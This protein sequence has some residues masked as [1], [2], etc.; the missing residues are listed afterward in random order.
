MS[1][2]PVMEPIT[3]DIVVGDER[4]GR[5]G[6]RERLASG[7]TNLRESRA[8]REWTVTLHGALWIGG[9]DLGLVALLGKTL[10]L[11][12]TIL[13][14]IGII[15]FL[16]VL[17]L[18]HRGGHPGFSK[19]EMRCAIAATFMVVYFTM[20]GVL[21]FSN[22]DLSPVA[23]TLIKNF[24]YLVGGV[25]AFYFGSTA[26]VEHAAAKYGRTSGEGSTNKTP[27]PSS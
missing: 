18:S 7:A 16:G 15:T 23:R 14:G 22:M 12:I 10:D 8:G 11:G 1:A 2:G 26:V 5:T 24:T 9:L 3:G 21:L 13:P 19:F 6:I 25:I 27:S 17:V 20:L 4:H